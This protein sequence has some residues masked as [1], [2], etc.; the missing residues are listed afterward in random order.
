MYDM[1]AETPGQAGRVE[2]L[3]AGRRED[4]GPVGPVGPAEPVGDV[5]SEAGRSEEVSDAP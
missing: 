5:V 2:V 3:F 1:E 4:A